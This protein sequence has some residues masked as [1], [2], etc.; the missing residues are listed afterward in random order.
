MWK[1]TCCNLQVHIPV[2]RSAAL[3]RDVEAFPQRDV[4]AFL[5][6]GV[7]AFVWCGVERLRE[8]KQAEALPLTERTHQGL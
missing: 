4:E 3:Q 8:E 6:C 5:W 1:F 2:C 7:E